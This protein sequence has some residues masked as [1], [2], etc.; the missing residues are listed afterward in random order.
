MSRNKKGGSG[1]KKVRWLTCIATTMLATGYSTI[2]CSENID[3]GT[4]QSMFGEP[5]TTSA[6]GV[7]QVASGVAANMTIITADEIRQAGTRSIPQIIGVYVPGIDILQ[8]GYAGFDVGIRGYQ[9]PAMPR[10]LVLVDGRQVFLDDYSYTVWNNIPVNIDDIRQIEVVKGPSSALFGSNAAGGV[11]NIVTYSPLY[12]KNNVVSA[13][14]G[15]ERTFGS[16][17]T[18]TKNGEWWGT[19][20]SVGGY[21]ANEFNTPKNPVIDETSIEPYKRYATDSSVFQVTPNLQVSSEFTYSYS[22]Q[23]QGVPAS[24]VGSDKETSYSLRGG[25]QWQ[26]DY[27]LIIN[28]NYFNHAYNYLAAPTISGLL[29]FTV[30]LTVSKLEDQFK[31]GADNTFRLNVEYRN[32]AYKNSSPNNIIPESP[33][34]QEDNYAASAAWLW[35]VNDKLSWTNAARFDHLDMTETGTLPPQSYY[36]YADYGHDINTLSAN[37]GLNYKATDQD[38]FVLSYGRG[39][40]MPSMIESALGIY[41][42]TT[43]PAYVQVTGN[44]KLKPT[45]VQNY[46]LDYERKIPNIFSI[47]KFAVF[48]QDNQDLKSFYVLP[49]NPASLILNGHPTV[50]FTQAND[51]SSQ[52]WGGEVELKGAKD[53]FRWD[54]SYSL[55][56]VDDGQQALSAL[57]YTGSAPEHHFRLNG[58]YTWNKWEFDANGQYMTS[59]NMQQ[60]INPL[61]KKVVEESGYYSFGGRVGYNI[62]DQFILAISG[63]NLNRQY[64]QESPYPA[65]ERTALVTLTGKF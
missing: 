7:P 62:N 35:Q 11:I 57:D 60:A 2:A 16:E 18:M 31:I 33:A 41:L 4:L 50:V 51:G 43:P 47:A 22:R 10:L 58:G 38:T 55:S 56:R 36:S 65:V 29:P 21:N 39:V 63:T 59:T 32:K 6:I 44:P 34:L 53:G 15:S 37:S 26:T 3:Y 25:F 12:D 64:I 61:Q 8:T 54:T 9:Q 28:D 45:I 48:Y 20:T 27:G 5:V 1:M 23:N 40:D 30:D 13:Y 49:I 19:K 42:P 17:A 46:E 14:A 24:S 52:G